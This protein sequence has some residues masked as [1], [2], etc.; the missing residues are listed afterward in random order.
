MR[1]D[2]LKDENNISRLFMT[3]S[4]HKILSYHFRSWRLNFSLK[5][6]QIMHKK[7]LEDNVIV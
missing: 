3:I 1:V 2:F 6:V 4:L 7:I 5:M